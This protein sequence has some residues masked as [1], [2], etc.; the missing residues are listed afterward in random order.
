MGHVSKDVKHALMTLCP[1]DKR[2]K[3]EFFLCF[4]HSYPH[5]LQVMWMKFN[6]LF[7]ERSNSLFG[8]LSEA[9]GDRVSLWGGEGRPWM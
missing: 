7:E 3:V 8:S 5:P 2:L 4:P 1:Q 9:P 6:P